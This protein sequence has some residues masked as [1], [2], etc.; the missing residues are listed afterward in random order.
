MAHLD[1]FIAVLRGKKEA[2][3]RSHLI[4]TDKDYNVGFIMECQIL[5]PDDIAR[6]F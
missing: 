5:S 6:R 1:K 2:E 4:G 3:V